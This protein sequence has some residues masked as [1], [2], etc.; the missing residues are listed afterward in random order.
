MSPGIEPGEDRAVCRQGERSGRD[1]ILKQHPAFG[2]GLER[3]SRDRPSEHRQPVGA[4][5]VDRH[6]HDAVHG[7]RSVSFRRSLRRRPARRQHEGQSQ[8]DHHAKPSEGWCACPSRVAAKS[9]QLEILTH[10]SEEVSSR[11]ADPSSALSAC[12]KPSAESRVQSR[13]P[14]ISCRPMSPS[15]GNRK[16]PRIGVVEGPPPWGVVRL[17]SR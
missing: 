1:R 9:H 6:Q 4:Q 2:E 11:E 16:V 5:R 13:V 15:A 10:R 17:R 14:G 12:R 8:R 7:G 3:G